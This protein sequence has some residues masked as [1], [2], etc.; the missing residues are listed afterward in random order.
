MKATVILMEIG[1]SIITRPDLHFTMHF[2][3][4][5]TPDHIIVVPKIINS[6]E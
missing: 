6:Q 3:D 1:K 5:I 2:F 4:S